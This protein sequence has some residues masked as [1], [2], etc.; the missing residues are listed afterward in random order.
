MLE[1]ISQNF[2]Y[3][4]TI[5]EGVLIGG[6]GAFVQSHLI[7]D[8]IKVISMGIPDE[9]IQHGSREDLLDGLG[10]NKHGIV[11]IISTGD[12]LNM[13]TDLGLHLMNTGLV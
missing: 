4:I 3:I 10:L 9:Y 6:F 11:N 12:S 5:E 13:K 2:S 8:N 7:N 1:E